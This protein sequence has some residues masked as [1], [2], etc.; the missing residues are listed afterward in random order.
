MHILYCWGDT[1][2]AF[3]Q[4]KQNAT[5]AKIPFYG[6]YT[7]VDPVVIAA[8]GVEKFRNDNFEIIIVDTRLV[9][10]LVSS[11][12]FPYAIFRDVVCGHIY[13]C[14]YFSPAC[15]D[16]FDIGSAYT[17]T[18]AVGGTNKRKVCSRRCCRCPTPSS[19]ITSCSSWTLQLGRP[20]RHRW[21][22]IDS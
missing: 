21:V 20:V 10:P 22:H 19:R 1:S 4:L 14:S 2:G 16:R 9:I 13:A 7:E 11:R 5:K 6:S 18:G 3:D 17:N 8:D 12:L 15:R